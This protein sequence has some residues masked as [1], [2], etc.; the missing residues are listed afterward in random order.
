M[1]M[2]AEILTQPPPPA[3]ERI[4]YGPHAS[5]F[6]DLRV[7]KGHGP[8]PVIIALHGGFWRA[9]YDLLHLGHLCAA[10]TREGFATWSIEYRRLGEA[11]SGWPGTFEDVAAAS[12]FVTTL[13]SKHRLDLK[14]VVTLGHSAGGHL[15]L[16]LAGRHKLPRQ[17]P[18]H[19]T[20]VLQVKGAVALAPV[21]DLR[22][23]EKLNLSRGIVR[24][25]LGGTPE[26]VADRYALASPAEL[27]PLGVPQI[28][29][30]GTADNIVPYSMSTRYVSAAQQAGDPVTLE[31]LP[32]VGHFEPI[33]PRSA[34]WPVVLKAVNTVA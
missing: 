5:Q 13:M 17:N 2:S 23:G 25:L 29:V 20:P 10:L 7:P 24:D 30:H 12:A 3:D 26:T 14:R 1:H 27:L 33:D 11:G 8:H 28:L 9:Q 15:A 31:S 32:G 16:W 6:G 21:S 4:A 22:L 34:A 19:A 18:F